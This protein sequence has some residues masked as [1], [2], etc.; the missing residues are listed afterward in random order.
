MD[1]EQ[2]KQLASESIQVFEEV[3]SIAETKLLGSNQLFL[4]SFATHNPATSSEAINNLSAAQQQT[5]QAYL[6]LSKEPALARIVAESEDG[7]QITIFI[8]RSTAVPLKSGHLHASYR[9]P[10]GRLAEIEVG[11]EEAISIRGEEQFY[12]VLEKT[13]FQACRIDGD[14]DSSPSHYK[15]EDTDVYTIDSLRPFLSSEAINSE[16]ATTDEPPLTLPEHVQQ[17]EAS[18][19]A[20]DIEDLDELLREEEL[21]QH[22]TKGL[23]HQ[24]LTAMELR[25]Q[26][27]LDKIQ[28]EIFRLP[29]NSQLV[30]LGPP[31][32]GKTTTLIKRLGQ[33]IDWESLTLR[34]QQLIEKSGTSL[35][36][37]KKWI[38]FTPSELLKLY[39]Q[40][41]F[42]REGVPAPDS[43]I[44]T[45]DSYVRDF[46]RNQL[47]I[48]R[49]S[50]GGRFSLKDNAQ[51]IRTE[52]IANPIALFADFK[53]TH[54]SILKNRYKLAIS[55]LEKAFA[56]EEQ[57]AR[58]YP[59][60]KAKHSLENVLKKLNS[61][62]EDKNSDITTFFTAVANISNHTTL[63]AA[64]K[65]EREVGERLLKEQRNLV[66]NRLGKD[67]FI[68]LG[69]IA[70]ELQ[71]ESL[72]DNMGDENGEIETNTTPHTTTPLNTA[73]SA[74]TSAIRSLA[75]SI[76]NGKKAAKKGLSGA[77]LEY[78]AENVPD[79]EI[80]FTIGRSAVMQTALSTLLNAHRDYIKRAYSSYTI[81]RRN[82]TPRQKFYT[83][84]KITNRE[85]TSEELD[86]IV[87]FTLSFARE[88]LTLSHIKFNIENSRYSYLR[89]IEQTF[90]NQV[91]VDEATDFSPIQLACMQCLT[92]MHTQSFFACGDINQRITTAGISSR[93]QL[94]KLPIAAEIK[95][96]QTVYRQ[97]RKLNKFSTALLKL[98]HGDLTT[99]GQVSEHSAHTGCNPVMCEHATDT[100]QAA[101]W[102]AERI[103]E[104]ERS[105]NV[106]PTIAVLVNSEDAVRP[107]CQ[108]LGEE[109][110]EIHVDVVACDDGRS[111]GGE[112]TVQVVDIRHIKGLEFEAVF[113]VGIDQL[114]QN[115][116]ELFERYLYVGATRAATYLGLV[117]HGVL[118]QKLEPVRK[119]FDSRFA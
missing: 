101:R 12:Y 105:V 106:L 55:N 56:N 47:E 38:M 17:E 37:S 65:T 79:E 99:V 46:A 102:L 31:G 22:M 89:E 111:L 27:I 2:I 62:L 80:L 51:S 54:Q 118:P 84:I 114:A 28:G 110:K 19:S 100:A 67:H 33:K 71:E 39:L 59:E 109:L 16:A 88:L 115:L 74:Y 49:S 7:K 50:T 40:E 5:K 45:W 81:Y 24:V 4:D 76:Y 75:R 20:S 112:K 43:N 10:M 85:I 29:I 26:A 61:L 69:K 86:F 53:A 21:S 41:A 34:E 36:H 64:M 77:I 42:N 15:H 104:V 57:V 13:V 87:W 73:V 70:I 96:I 98:Q 11:D 82:A 95:Y 30:I 8:A 91:M 119:Y 60:K 9:S 58:F 93:E 107:M 116:P 48:L 90:F 6:H 35:E 18:E 3:S 68:N 94:E 97:S 92:S 44:R 72:P 14:W 23:K 108:L 1:I 113:F 32:T 103:K 78:L 117:C 83:G 25:D 66:Y 52:I 63:A